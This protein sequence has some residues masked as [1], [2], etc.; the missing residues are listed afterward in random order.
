[1]SA[2][3][4]FTPGGNF[5]LSVTTST[6]NVAITGAGTTL[7]LANVTAQECFVAFGASTVVATTGGFSVP[8]NSQVFVTIP[9]GT[10]HVA[11]ITASGTATLRISRG[12]GGI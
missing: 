4:A 3:P 8:G 9:S 2:V 7:R 6:G 12:D 5:S 10:T 11:A 1:M